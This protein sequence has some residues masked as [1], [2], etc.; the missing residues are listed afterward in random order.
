VIVTDRT[1]AVDMVTD[2]YDGFVV[3]IRD[4]RAIADKIQ[5]FHDNPGEVARMG[6]NARETAE[7][8]SWGKVEDAYAELFR[9]VLE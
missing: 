3:P 9:R 8:Y 2:G 4:P 7:A 6:N 1:G 5:Y